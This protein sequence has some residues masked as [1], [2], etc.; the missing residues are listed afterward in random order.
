ML[1]IGRS[2]I[3]LGIA[4]VLVGA[5]VSFIAKVPGIGKLPGDILIQ[6]KNFSFY[7]PIVT[8]ILISFFVSLFF[9]LIGKR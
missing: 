7:F 2:L 6:G 1:E 5:V 3:L 4:L 9:W 8:C